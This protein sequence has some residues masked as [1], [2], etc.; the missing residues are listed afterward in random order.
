M[1]PH[2]A[3]DKRNMCQ[4]T[5]IASKTGMLFPGFA[6]QSFCCVIGEGDCFD[7]LRET[8]RTGSRN[9]SYPRFCASI[10]LIV[11]ICEGDCFDPTRENHSLWVSQ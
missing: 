9:D 11:V 1:K 3:L 4:T 8:I 10:F 7:P 2:S 5:V 6:R